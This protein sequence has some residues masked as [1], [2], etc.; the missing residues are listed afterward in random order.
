MAA[1]II[2]NAPR[3]HKSPRGSGPTIASDVSIPLPQ[4]PIGFRSPNFAAGLFWEAVM[5]SPTVSRCA[6]S[7]G[8]V[9]SEAPILPIDLAAS[10][11]Y[12]IYPSRADRSVETVA[13]VESCRKHNRVK[14]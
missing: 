3:R 11:G 9:R 14:L 6:T 1:I 7:V 8:F 2:L 13:W 4:L 5:S 12:P 10:G